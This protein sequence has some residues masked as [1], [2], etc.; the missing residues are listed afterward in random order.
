MLSS[1]PAISALTKQDDKENLLSV[2]VNC[3]GLFENSV[4]LVFFL[5]YFLLHIRP[6]ETLLAGTTEAH[7]EQKVQEVPCC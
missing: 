5:F 1:V 2:E 4:S 3:K 7:S 6:D